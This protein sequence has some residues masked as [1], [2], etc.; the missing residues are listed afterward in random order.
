MG[1]KLKWFIAVAFLL[2][3]N[4]WLLLELGEAASPVKNEIVFGFSAPITGA[5]S[6]AGEPSKKGYIAWAEMVNAGGGILVKEYGKKLPVRMV[7]YDDKTDPTT[8]AKIYLHVV[9]QLLG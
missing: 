9:L 2:L 7:Y 5:L 8:A 4:P 1:K 6:Y 3:I